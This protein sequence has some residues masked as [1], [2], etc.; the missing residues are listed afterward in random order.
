MCDL[1]AVMCEECGATEC[2]VCAGLDPTET[3][4]DWS[5]IYEGNYLCKTH[6]KTQHD[7]AGIPRPDSPVG[8]PMTLATKK[9]L[10]IRPGDPRFNK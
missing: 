3:D 9:R 4:R 2:V 8:E 5:T 10:A 7:E 6:R 1:H